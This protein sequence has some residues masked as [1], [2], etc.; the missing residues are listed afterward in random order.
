M[1]PS[2]LLLVDKFCE[3]CAMPMHEVGRTKGLMSDLTNRPHSLNMT[4]T[5]PTARKSLS[6]GFPN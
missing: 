1:G 3:L 5:A 4:R 6:C 2:D